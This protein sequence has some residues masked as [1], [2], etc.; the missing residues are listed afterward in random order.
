MKRDHLKNKFLTSKSDHDRKVH[1][2]QQNLRVK[3]IILRQG[4]KRFFNN[5]I[6]PYVDDNK[7]FWEIVKLVFAERMK[8]K[9]K[10]SLIEKLFTRK[11]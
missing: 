11:R 9:S 3:L 4:K 6:V 2:K 5:I 10:I 1:N 8:S 7:T